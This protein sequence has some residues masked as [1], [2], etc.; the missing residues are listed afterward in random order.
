M[1]P[2]MTAPALIKVDKAT[3]YR[4]IANA[5]ENERYEYVGGRIVQQQSG[6]TWEHADIAKRFARIIERQLSDSEWSVLSGSDRGVETVTT[7]RYPDVVVEPA[8]PPAGSLSTDRPALLVE[9]LSPSSSDRDLTI[10]PAEYTS[11]PSLHCYIVASQTAPECLVWLR[12]GTGAFSTEG[13]LVSGHNQV[14]RIASLGILISLAEV[15]RG[16]AA[17]ES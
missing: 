5:P 12:S 11:L 1:A 14:I 16:M 10:K 3:F 4:F 17:G 9:V 13:E 7:V 8:P 15:Y 6:G 2:A